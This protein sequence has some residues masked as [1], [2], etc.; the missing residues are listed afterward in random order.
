MKAGPCSCLLLFEQ[1]LSLSDHSVDGPQRGTSPKLWD[2]KVQVPPM[3]QED[4]RK[5]QVPHSS[6]VKVMCSWESLPFSRTLGAGFPGTVVSSNFILLKRKP[7]IQAGGLFLAHQI[8][9]ILRKPSVW[10]VVP[11]EIPCKLGSVH[12]AT[13]WYEIVTR[14]K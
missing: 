4:T 1:P 3:F 5:F 9:R 13:G 10:D 14:F 7:K 8:S 2:I 6:L 11:Y 12:I